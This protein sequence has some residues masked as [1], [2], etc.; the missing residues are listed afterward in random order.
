MKKLLLPALATLLLAAC[1][2]GEIAKSDVQKALDHAPRQ[3]QV[4]VPFTL[5]VQ[6][7]APNEDPDYTVLGVPEI[8]LLKRLDN[9]KRA[10]PAAI[11]QMNILVNAGIYEQKDNLRIGEGDHTMRY[12]VYRLTEKGRAYFSPTHKMPWLCIGK[13]KVNDINYFTEPTAAHGVTISQVSYQASL[14]TE[15]WARKLLRN[16]P[17]FAGL[18]SEMERKITLMKTNEGWRDVRELHQ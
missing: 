7:R 14:D 2:S 4:C 18:D 8:R 12:L 5:D 10:N 9:G 15:R 17:H 13:Q 16:S 11:E 3:N 6:H 1:S